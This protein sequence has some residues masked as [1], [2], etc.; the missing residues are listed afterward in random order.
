MHWDSPVP[1]HSMK[2]TAATF[3]SLEI[4]MAN[5]T[6][7]QASQIKQLSTHEI[8]AELFTVYTSSKSAV[9]GFANNADLGSVGIHCELMIAAAM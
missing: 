6:N 5:T 4:A 9:I 8:S 3:G 1:V 2:Q 7:S